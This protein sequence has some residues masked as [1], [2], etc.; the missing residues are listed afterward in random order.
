VPR[1]TFSSKRIFYLLAL[2]L[3]LRLALAWLPER[4]FFYLVSD[5]AYYY[6]SIARNLAARG[7]FSADGI[8]Q[9]NG[10]HPLWLFV[11]TPIYQLFGGTHAWFNIHLALTLSA[12]FDTAA[13]FFVHKILEKLGRPQLGF[14]A[15]AFYAV[16][17]Y[18]LL[19][20]MNGLEIA[21]NNFFLSLLVYFSLPAE[22][23]WH[24]KNWLLLGGICGLTLLS[25]TDNLFAVGALL[26][27]L[28]LRHRDFGTVTKTAT[29][30]V[31]LV[32]PW[33]V[34]NYLTFGTVMQT[35]GTAYPY[36]YHQQ[37]LQ[38]HGSF[39]SFALIPHLLLVG[40]NNFIQNSQH[41][42]NW[43]LSLLLGGFLAFALA[44]RPKSIRPLLWTLAGA[45]LFLFFHVFIR[46][47]VRPWY[48]QA[49]FVLTLPAVALA[50]ERQRS[51]WIKLGAAFVLV[52][53]LVWLSNWQFRKAD[54]SKAMLDVVYQQIPSADLVGVFNSGFVQYFTDQKII[55]LDGLVNNEVLRYYKERNGLS[56]LRARQ[57]RWLI[58]IPG[59]IGGLFGPFWGWGAEN[60]LEL[61]KV[62][63]GVPYAENNLV[64]LKVLPEGQFSP[65]ERRLPIWQY[66]KMPQY[67][68]N[69]TFY[70]PWKLP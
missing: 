58:D 46:W 43:I 39:F 29:I 16:N 18:G 15:A 54:R 13:S 1:G 61:E 42:G 40:A 41:Y 52:S 7:I 44:R 28:L 50:L 63:P 56:Y 60:S 57:I 45:G 30:S 8:A 70:F 2:G 4:F 33:L 26:V 55:N 67:S 23:G 48:P 25:R 10:F 68:W 9:T 49:A 64:V 12:F 34:Y 37:F 47:S 3:F 65:P 59:Y 17:P 27:Y 38:D 19:H 32:L 62:I 6:F 51:L 22:A 69:T 11:I 21:Q 5:D 20:T 53:Q 35:S 14:W 31:L 66:W 24:K 36:K